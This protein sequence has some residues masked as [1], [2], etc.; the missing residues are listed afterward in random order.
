[1]EVY[2]YQDC[3]RA[4][5]GEGACPL[6]ALER[7]ELVYPGYA[8]GLAGAVSLSPDVLH[9]EA[10]NVQ[11]RL[12]F[13]N[14]GGSAGG[15]ISYILQDHTC[16]ITVSS[17]MQGTYDPASCAMS[18][19][20][21]LTYTYEGKACPS[22]CGS[23]PSSETACPVTRSGT[24]PWQAEIKNDRVTGGIGSSSGDLGLVGFS[25]EP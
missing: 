19:T 16:T 6:E 22:V 25:G 9:S 2:A 13:T 12:T 21:Q 7:C 8:G 1:V 14:T 15:S 23:G 20:A 18:G 11:T 24:V 10:R 4:A 3:L 17:S 5:A